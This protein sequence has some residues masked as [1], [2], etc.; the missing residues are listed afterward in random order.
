MRVQRKREQRTQSEGPTARRRAPA[1]VREVLQ[2]PGAPLESGPR[3]FMERRFGH[4]FSR[5]R[6]HADSAAASSAK[7]AN[8]LAYTVRNNVVFGAGLYNPGSPPGR[9]L[10][11]HELAH[12]VQ[13]AN[14]SGATSQ[15]ADYESEASTA[16]HRIEK[17]ERAFVRLAA[18]TAMQ[19][20]V[21]PGSLAHA[22]PA[23]SASPLLA[24]AIGSVSLD[25]FDTGKADISGGN[26]AKLAR[27]ADTIM[28]LFR[29][30]PASTIRVIGYTDA[31][32]QEG[33]NQALGQARADSV[34]A[35]L[36]QMGI[37]EVA[38]HT[39]SRGAS[40]LL[41]RTRKAEP[42][43]RRVEV[44]F[45]TSQL[46][47][48]ALSQGLTLTPQPTQPTPD[49]GKGVLPGVGDLC[50]KDPTLCYGKGHGFPDG[51]PTVPEGALQPIPD[52]T[53]FDLMDVQGANE[54]YTSHGRSPQEGGD[55]RQT[56][57]T[58][59]WKYRLKWRLPKD[60]A[61]KAANKELSSTA[62]QA[63][64]RDNPNA[65]DRLDTDI[66]RADPN[67]TKLGP[68][69]ITLWRF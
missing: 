44:H 29:Q 6:V 56:W 13:Q 9:Q 4:D 34:Q 62:G 36:L 41:V 55:L 27:T 23:E 47:H 24:A 42:R 35:A 61:A 20:Q 11:A 65:A 30:Y 14:S 3:E 49:A 68:A 52:D 7:S 63:Q 51:P 39:E 66:Q 8:A 43:N 5:V 31:V 33:D 2:A 40:D 32:G 37:P 60:L 25:G 38:I 53:P 26:Q 15:T 57:A 16:S 64:S 54:A 18:P 28:T 67:A 21:F 19:R 50:I 69:N 46:L 12:V 48:G 22:D 58:L 10:L 59:Y 17:G 1:A 45:E